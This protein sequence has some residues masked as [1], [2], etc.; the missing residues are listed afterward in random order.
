MNL[1]YGNQRKSLKFIYNCN[2]ENK[3][4]TKVILSKFINCNFQ[5]TSQICRDLQSDGFITLVGVNYDPKI[6]YRGIEYFSAEK[7]YIFESIL[8]SIVCPIL[9]ST[10]TTLITLW[11]KSLL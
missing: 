1:L 3:H 10:I 2:K 7:R 5:E 8:K 4:V 11:L 9:V 6:T